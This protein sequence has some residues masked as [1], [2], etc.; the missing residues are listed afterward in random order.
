MTDIEKRKLRAKIVEEA[1]SWL[2]TPW[3]HEGRVKGAGIDCGMLILEVYEHV[4]LIPRVT[5]PH[6]GP[7]FMLHRSDE[8]Y[9]ELILRFADEI[10]SEPLPG[11]AIVCKQGRVYSHG[12]IIVEWPMIIHA[13]SPE[14]CVTYGDMRLD[15]ISRWPRRFFRH[16]ELA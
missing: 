9:V 8:W 6:Y 2:G 11:D 1:K 15:P 3:H 12:G 13:Y 5:P 16:K 14:R 4:G 10:S 7:D